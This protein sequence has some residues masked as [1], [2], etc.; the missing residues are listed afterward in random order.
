MECDRFANIKQ[1]LNCLHALHFHIHLIENQ[2]VCSSFV[3]ILSFLLWTSG[4]LKIKAGHLM[5]TNWR[6]WKLPD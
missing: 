3:V 6:L 1:V 2:N 4:E 5:P